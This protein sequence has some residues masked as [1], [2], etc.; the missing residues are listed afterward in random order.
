MFLLMIKN[1]LIEAFSTAYYLTGWTL[2]E[3]WGFQVTHRTTK[4]S[5]DWWPARKK[6]ERKYKSIDHLCSHCWL[7]YGNVTNCSLCL[8]LTAS[9]I[10]TCML[11]WALFYI[12]IREPILSTHIILIA[13]V[14]VRDLDL[15]IFDNLS[16]KLFHEGVLLLKTGV[17]CQINM[18]NKRPD[19][20]KLLSWCM[21]DWIKLAWRHITNTLSWVALISII[22]P[23]DKII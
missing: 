5:L 18:K 10:R 15:H 13:Y 12:S 23:S 17:L 14:D 19:V 22:P 6:W 20:I 21:L 4:D 11:S 16:D 7:E 3:G 2:P 1:S 9:S 8:S